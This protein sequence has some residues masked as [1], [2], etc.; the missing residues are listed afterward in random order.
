MLSQR[1]LKLQNS[2]T[3]EKCHWEW[4]WRESL[5]LFTLNKKRT[6]HSYNGYKG[7][8]SL[9]FYL[10]KWCYVFP[11]KTA[12][13]AFFLQREI[14]FHESKHYRC[15]LCYIVCYSTILFFLVLHLLRFYSI[16]CEIYSILWYVIN[17]LFSWI[18]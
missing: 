1:T 18:Y 5:Y 16:R 15:F 13:I 3:K 6:Y 17:N 7:R 14:K 8:V 10:N 2:V 12:V 11:S 9:P 4:H